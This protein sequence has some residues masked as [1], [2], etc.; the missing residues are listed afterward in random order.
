MTYLTR[1]NDIQRMGIS[2]GSLFGFAA[3]VMTLLL[4]KND[5]SQ[6]QLAGPMMNP[7]ELFAALLQVTLVN[8]AAGLLLGGGVC[9]AA[10][11]AYSFFSGRNNRRWLSDEENE[12]APYRTIV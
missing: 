10:A 1:K 12:A 11:E 7:D 8:A 5:L 9:T 2:V 4:E 6:H 3:G